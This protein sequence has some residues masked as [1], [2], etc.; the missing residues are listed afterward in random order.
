MQ[1]SMHIRITGLLAVC[2]QL[3]G[4]FTPVGTCVHVCVYVCVWLRVCVCARG[5]YI[6]IYLRNRG[7]RGIIVFGSVDR[8]VHL[9]ETS[10]NGFA[11][12][13]VRWF[14]HI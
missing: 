1:Q 3:Y 8:R 7:E 11:I 9:A 4:L 12:S 10:D 13:I 6:H 14:G 5:P 2:V